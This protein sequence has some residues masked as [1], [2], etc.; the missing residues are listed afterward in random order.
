MMRISTSFRKFLSDTPALKLMPD[1][2]EFVTTQEAA[3]E[4]GY[5]ANHVR[6]MVRKGYL[7]AERFGHA[8]LITKT[9]LKEFKENSTK[10]RKHDRRKIDMLKCGK[11]D[12][13]KASKSCD[14]RRINARK[15]NAL[16]LEAVL[17]QV[18][19]PDYFNA[20]LQEV[21]NQMSDVASLEAEIEEKRNDLR[22]VERAISNLLELA[23]AFG[24]GAAL[25]R[26]KQREAERSQ[27][28]IEI[29]TLEARRDL[30]RVE[31]TPEALALALDIW[32]KRILNA[33]ESGDVAALRNLLAHFVDKIEMDY[34]SVKIWYTY[35]L[36]SLNRPE[37]ALL[38][39][40]APFSGSM[41]V[42]MASPASGMDFSRSLVEA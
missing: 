14:G 29:Q 4:L 42:S 8:L 15:V 34:T 9:S 22:S 41:V 10:Y 40:N 13:Q 19:T 21:Q 30:Q 6:R 24:V 16:V 37:S 33:Q 12:R 31:V 20:L 26:L 11:R 36:K 32:R 23:E 25:E 1:L 28:V 27:L 7:K 5:H 38:N 18:L 17:H 2:S 39:S 3:Q 35:P